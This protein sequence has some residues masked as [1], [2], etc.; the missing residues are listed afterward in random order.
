[1][2]RRT[3]LAG[4]TV[5]APAALALPGTAFAQG[6][7]DGGERDRLQELLEAVH[8]AGMP[9]LFAEVRADY[10]R[11]GLAA[12][13][14][15]VDSGRPVQPWFRHRVGSITKTFVAT[16]VLQLA[17]EGRLGLDDPI[18]RYLPE[19]ATGAITIRM[20]LNHTSGVFNYTNALLQTPDDVINVGKRVY[21]PQELIAIALSQPPTGPPGSPFSYSNTGYIF[22]GLLIERLTGRRYADE[23]Q[24]RILRP[25]GLHS[26]YFPGGFPRIHGPHSEAYVP[27]IDGNLRDFS[28]YNMTWAWAAGELISTPQDL[29]RFYRALLGGRL[30]NARLLREMQTTNPFDPTV[31][32]A[33]GYGLGLYWLGLPGGERAWGHDGG[34]VGHVTLSVHGSRSLTMAENMA[35]YSVPGEPH[36]IDI[37]R[38]EFVLAALGV[39]APA[40]T[41]ATTP[42][43]LHW[44]PDVKAARP[45]GTLS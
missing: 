27:W 25:L 34:T 4:L 2:H 18:T 13:L 30:L 5:A 41:T 21:R 22:L 1:M 7:P 16:V 44:T 37:A 9:G 32:D 14:A 42:V 20:L 3:L 40:A 39:N 45:F 10:R 26:S 15:D 23:V 33:G 38:V 36:P 28:V 24:R 29:N 17:G 31:P 12:G 6:N 43:R 19:Y 11:W 35:F 8:Q